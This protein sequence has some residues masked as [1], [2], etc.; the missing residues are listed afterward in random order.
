MRRMRA[1]IASTWLLA[2]LTKGIFELFQ[3]LL[4]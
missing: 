2:L 4:R 1:V 3:R